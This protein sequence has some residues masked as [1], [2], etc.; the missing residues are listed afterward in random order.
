MPSNKHQ[1]TKSTANVSAQNKKRPRN[2]FSSSRGR[3]A[4][5]ASR[6]ARRQNERE[7]PDSQEQLGDTHPDAE[8]LHDDDERLS[9]SEESDGDGLFFL[10]G[11][12]PMQDKLFD[13]LHTMSDTESNDDS[14]Q[15]DESDSTEGHSDTEDEDDGET[16]AY[17][18]E[19]LPEG[20]HLISMEFHRWTWTPFADFLI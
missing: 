9:A 5:G 20:Q 3:G 11:I 4:A 17:Q 19:A 2:N 10:D 13:R 16:I 7:V 18:F 6:S 8:T 12:N 14:N 1:R 15:S